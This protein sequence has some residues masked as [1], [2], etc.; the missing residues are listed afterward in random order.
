MSNRHLPLYEF[1]WHLAEAQKAGLPLR[2]TIDDIAATAPSRRLRMT[3]TDIALFLQNGRTLSDALDA[4]PRIFDATLRALV[5]SGEGAGRMV[6]AFR[7]C[8]EIV[9]LRATRARE[10]RRATREPKITA[11]IVVGLGAI[12]G[13]QTLVDGALLLLFLTVVVIAGWR[14]SPAF[15][16]FVLSALL[17][18]PVIG[19]ILRRDA[20]ARFAESLVFLYQS[21]VPLRE[22][23]TTAA[24]VQPAAGMKS[25]F[26][27]IAAR[28][29]EKSGLEQAFAAEVDADRLVLSM[30][31]AGERSGN[32]GASLS[33]AV[34]R[35]DE[36]NDRSITALRQYT[37]PMLAI[38]LGIVIYRFL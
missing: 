26:L 11:F 22:A 31:R 2:T 24:D 8:A 28:L 20:W 38:V 7:R 9:R 10:M 13:A 32:L 3:Y 30:V 16:T 4:H 34:L 29:G 35:L 18:M 33:E 19:G 6:E 15:R 25:V 14:L 36:E 12:S 1:F 23:A 37:G 17:H 21:G 27:R 5:R